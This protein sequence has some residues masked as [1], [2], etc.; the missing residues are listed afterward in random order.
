MASHLLSLVN[1]HLF[2]AVAILLLYLDGKHLLID[3]T[4]INLL[5]PSKL[6]G[7]YW[8]TFAATTHIAE[9]NKIKK[10][11]Q[12][13]QTMGAEMV[14]MAFNVFGGMGPGAHRIRTKLATLHAISKKNKPIPLSTTYVWVSLVKT[15]LLRSMIW[16]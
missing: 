13:C 16:I 4:V 3:V 11:T 14:G 10:Y 6:K 8:T 2:D 12:L 1:T 9:E 7:P 15:I 5:A